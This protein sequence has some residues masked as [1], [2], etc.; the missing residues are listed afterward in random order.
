MIIR[1]E[2]RV[3]GELSIEHAFA[4]ANESLCKLGAETTFS[5]LVAGTL[6]QMG[7]THVLQIETLVTYKHIQVTYSIFTTCIVLYVWSMTRIETFY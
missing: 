6:V 1:G 3:K 4:V 5:S 7:L 2:N